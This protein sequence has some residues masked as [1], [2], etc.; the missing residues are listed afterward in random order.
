[1]YMDGWMDAPSIEELDGYIWMDVSSLDEPYGYSTILLYT[2][3][4]MVR[5][6]MSRIATGQDTY[7]WMDASSTDES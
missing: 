7:G 6:Q 1:M 2:Y 4:W 3:G 5:A